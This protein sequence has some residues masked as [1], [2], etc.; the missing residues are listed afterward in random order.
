M[1]N[2]PLDFVKSGSLELTLHFRGP[3]FV[4]PTVVWWRWLA[5]T[6]CMMDVEFGM[7]W[8]GFTVN[9]ATW[10]RIGDFLCTSMSGSGD[11]AKNNTVHSVVG[12]CI[13]LSTVHTAE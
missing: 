5:V 7:E 12:I 1:R 2:K 6:L 8:N 9:N 3:I 11:C 4:I 10:V 13:V